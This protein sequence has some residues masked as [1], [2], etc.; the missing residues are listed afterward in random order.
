[1]PRP[2]RERWVHWAP[3]VTY[4]TPAGAGVSEGETVQLT[5]EELEALR[6][7][8]VEGLEQ[9]ACAAQ[10]GVS[11]PTFQRILASAR[12]KVAGALVAGRALH[13]HGGHYR[14]AGG[15]FRC[16]RCAQEF[17]TGPPTPG[18]PA[19]GCPR[20]RG[21]EVDLLEGG[22]GAEPPAPHLGGPPQMRPRRIPGRGPADAGPRGC[23]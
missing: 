20:C 2:P 21:L 7:K 3:R 9:E 4:F 6:L 16:R 12:R 14:L 23:C 19:H 15:R 13:V 1:M 18:S 17:E 11:R 10:M 22:E 8:D 5:V